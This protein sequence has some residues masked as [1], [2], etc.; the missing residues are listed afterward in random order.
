MEQRVIKSTNIMMREMI[1]FEIDFCCARVVFKRLLDFGGDEIQYKTKIC[2]EYGRIWYARKPKRHIYRI[3]LFDIEFF[4]KRN[5]RVSNSIKI[6]IEFN[7]SNIFCRV[8]IIL[9]WKLFWQNSLAIFTGD[10]LLFI[11]W[12]EYLAMS[13]LL[14]HLIP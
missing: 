10:L 8:I 11:G 12:I 4:M 13:W 3:V 7:S 6:F 14:P 5:F 9:E 1:L 2:V